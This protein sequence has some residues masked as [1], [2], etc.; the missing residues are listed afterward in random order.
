MLA[1]TCCLSCAGVSSHLASDQTKMRLSRLLLLA[2]VLSVTLLSLCASASQWSKE[3]HE[4]FELQAALEKAEAALSSRKGTTGSTGSKKV[5]FYS[6][7]GI[8]N[9]ATSS[10]IKRAYRKRSLELHPDKNSGV[11][12]AQKRFEQLGLVYKILRDD[13]KDRYDHFL[14]S[15]FPKWRNTGYFYER[16][17]PGLGSVV[18]G[19]VLFTMLV[20]VLISRLTSLQERAKILR[21]KHSAY[22]VAWGPRYQS[23]LIGEE[24]AKVSATEKKVKLPITG[25]P[26]L[27]AMP[28]AAQQSSTN[29]D[30][31]E[32][33]IR[34]SVSGA[35]SASHGCGNGS[36]VVEC[37]V[38]D[39]QVYLHDKF[40]EEWVILDEN[41]AQPSQFIQTWP[42]RFVNALINK[43]TGKHEDV[44][45]EDYDDADQAVTQPAVVTN[46]AAKKRNKKKAQ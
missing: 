24:G 26:D 13:R 1:R 5:N 21:L 40:S 41:D 22:L 10:E 14:R 23:I 25:F 17:R 2:I 15:G 45:Q 20:E 9:T 27:P 6:L 35:T 33:K 37:L 12:G 7:L 3:D 32:K 38:K 29:W 46:G 16:Y 19:I 30:E 34:Q 36:V 8:P 42:I 4:I 44:L 31:Q 28:T 43:V 39:K 18:V 11:K